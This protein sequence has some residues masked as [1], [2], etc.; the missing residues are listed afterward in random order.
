[1]QNNRTT[2]TTVDGIYLLKQSV[3]KAYEYNIDIEVVFV[4]F[5]QT[6][7]SLNRTKLI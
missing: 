5:Q 6:F 3:E 1:M 2:T 7:Y 4:D